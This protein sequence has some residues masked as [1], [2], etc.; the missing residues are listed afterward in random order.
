MT[1]RSMWDF[2]DWNIK[3]DPGTFMRRAGLHDDDS[4]CSSTNLKFSR[5]FVNEDGDTPRDH[6]QPLFSKAE[7]RSSASRNS[8]AEEKQL[9]VVRSVDAMEK[10]NGTKCMATLKA[11]LTDKNTYRVCAAMFVVLYWSFRLFQY[12]RE[13]GFDWKLNVLNSTERAIYGS[14]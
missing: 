9:G 12:L 13:K 7:R 6:Q 14:V 8:F 4:A 2:A 3:Y 5:W 11:L 10:N 1:P